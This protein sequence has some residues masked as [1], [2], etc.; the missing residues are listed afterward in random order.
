MCVCGFFISMKLLMVWI[1]CVLFRFMLLYRY[2][3]LYD[4]F[5]LLVIWMVV[6]CVN[7]FVLLVMKLLNVRIWLSCECLCMELFIGVCGGVV[8][9][10]IMVGV[11]GGMWYDWA[12]ILVVFIM[13]MLILVV[14]WFVVVS[15]VLWYMVGV[16]CRLF[17]LCVILLLVGR[18]CCG[19]ICCVFKGCIGIGVSDGCKVV[20]CWLVVGLSMNCMLMVVF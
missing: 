16:V 13:G 1:K 20:W 19:W 18:V 8:W 2:N 4:L 12:L 14:V 7:W 17:V 5:G 15:V 6:V 11:C 10:V 3:G 9:L